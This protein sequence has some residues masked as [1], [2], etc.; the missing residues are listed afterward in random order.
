[1]LKEKWEEKQ[2]DYLNKVDPE[3]EK[4]RV[5]GESDTWWLRS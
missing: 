4:K 5:M 2:S 1:V 3:T